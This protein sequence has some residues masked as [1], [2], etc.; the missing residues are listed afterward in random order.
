MLD[1]VTILDVTDGLS[2][3]LVLNI[4]DIPLDAFVLFINREGWL[5]GY[6]EN[7]DILWKLGD[8]HGDWF[9]FHSSQSIEI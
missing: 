3:F 9:S 1:A 2:I 4:I 6:H 7:L 5:V 8:I